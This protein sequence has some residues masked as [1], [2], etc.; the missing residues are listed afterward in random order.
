MFLTRPG[1][2]RATGRRPR[3]KTS[4]RPLT[5]PSSRLP[6]NH[7]ETFGANMT[8]ISAASSSSYQSPLQK[9]QD[10]LQAEINSGAISSTDQ[11]SLSSALTDI[12]S[13]LQN[14]RATDQ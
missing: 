3:E 9:L 10:E 1:Q 6:R 2:H 11:D 12:D 13:S 8:S 4:L 14:G 5:I 7:Q